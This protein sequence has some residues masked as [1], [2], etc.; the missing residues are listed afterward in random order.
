MRGLRENGGKMDG[1]KG[2]KDKNEGSWFMVL[3]MG[4]G[5]EKADRLIGI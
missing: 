5:R 3:E 2:G 1:G 4:D